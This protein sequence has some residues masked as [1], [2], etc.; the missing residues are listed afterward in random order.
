MVAINN[1]TYVRKEENGVTVYNA[2]DNLYKFYENLK[3]RDIVHI[4]KDEEKLEYLEKNKEKIN[5][6]IIYTSPFRI[7]WLIS[8]NCNLNCVYCFADDKMGKKGNKMHILK[9][10]RHILK[11]NTMVV[12]ITGGEPTLNPYIYNI[13]DKLCGKCAICIDTNGTVLLNDKLIKKIKE[14]NA[15]VRITIDTFN[16]TILN[17]VRIAKSS[18]LDQLKNIQQNIEKLRFANAL[19][20]VHTVVTMYNKDELEALANNLIALGVKRWNLYGVNYCEKC[21]D[22]YEQIKVEKQ[23]LEDIC[24]C[25]IYKYGDKLDISVHYDEEKY[26]ERAVILVDSDGKFFLDTIKSGI[27]FIGKN[28]KKPSKN[29][30]EK[31]LDVNAHCNGYLS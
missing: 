9:T 4:K 8:E 10:V 30:I 16:E 18:K 14:S 23:E 25:L 22:Y 11:L 29:E 17:K 7:N 21:K 20:M 5:K 15:L 27:R 1:I 26:N 12:G 24:K 2:E 3:Y 6:N 31:F 13:I 19:F 28:S